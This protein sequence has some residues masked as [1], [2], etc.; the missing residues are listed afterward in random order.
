MGSVNGLE[1]SR[2]CRVLLVEDHADTRDMLARLLSGSYDVRVAA[3]YETALTSAAEVTPHIVVTDVGLPGRDGMALM[4]A[5]RDRYR[6]PGVAVTGHVP[7]DPQ[8]FRDAGFIATLTKP[9]SFDALLDVLTHV[10]A[11]HTRVAVSQTDAA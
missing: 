11:G 1:D 7:E 8:L 5:L 6:V 10:C 3:C 2:P 4:R 9:I